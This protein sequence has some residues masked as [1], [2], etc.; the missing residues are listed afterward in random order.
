MT[1]PNEV[2]KK[3]PKLSRL[4]RDC[5]ITEKIDGTNASI[6]ILEDGTIIPCSKERMLTLED[7]N[8]GFARWLSEQNQEEIR[9]KLGVGQHY[10]EFWGQKIGRKYG[11]T[12][13]RFSLF[14]THRWADPESRPKCCGVVPVLYT[15][16]F[17]TRA[18]EAVLEELSIKGSV[19]APGFMDPEGIVIYHQ[20]A[21]VMFKKTIKDDEVPK[22]L[23]QP[24]HIKE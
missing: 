14:N 19:A 21:N 20:H 5:T 18:I 2:F 4:S 16:P 15:G 7:D 12:E 11:L 22:S 23:V 8:Q 3:M 9:T 13:K 1:E 24:Q 10:G 17:E 6:L